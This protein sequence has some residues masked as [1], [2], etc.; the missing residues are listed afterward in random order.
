M[1]KKIIILL[2]ASII[3][4][5][6][7]YNGLER[8]YAEILTFGTNMVTGAV[9]DHTVIKLEKHNEGLVFRVHTLIDGRKGSYPQAAQSLLLPLVI[10]LSWMVVLF[11]SLP[12]KTALKQALSNFGIFLVFQIFF[13]ILLT[14]YY[15]SDL[16]K[17]LFHVMLDT[18]YIFA[19]FLIIKDSLKYPDI[20][21][22]KQ[23]SDKEPVTF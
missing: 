19:I 6:L 3:I 1:K 4:T 16:A 9:N 11:Y 13:M 14:N 22:N 7:W 2:G 10:V 18:F 23:E 8:G 12:G 21:D 17:F 15:N 5:A 20:W